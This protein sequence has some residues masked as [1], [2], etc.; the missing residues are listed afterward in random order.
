MAKSCLNKLFFN[1]TFDFFWYII[2]AVWWLLLLLLTPF[3]INI[4]EK[5][6]KTIT[7]AIS[8]F[9]HAYYEYANK[10]WSCGVTLPSRIPNSVW[11]CAT[12]DRVH[13]LGCGNVKFVSMV[14]GSNAFFSS[15][16]RLIIDQWTV[17]HL[18]IIIIF[19]SS[20]S[21]LIQWIRDI[22]VGDN[23]T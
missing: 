18:S 2:R 16:G 21:I 20:W 12:L 9:A 6:N 17:P 13:T 3:Y 23:L 11:V 15:S 19:N 5:N 10:T 1:L 7:D 4:P 8:T 14:N 22:L